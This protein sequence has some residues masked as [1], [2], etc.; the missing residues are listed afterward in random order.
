[1]TF[2]SK[3]YQSYYSTQVSRYAGSTDSQFVS[4]YEKDIIKFLPA[5]KNMRILE[6]GCGHGSLIK[7][8]EKKGYKN[9]L[10]IDYSKE[11]VKLAKQ[12]GINNVEEADCI[13][14]LSNKP[15]EFDIV[16]GVDVIEHFTK[17]ELLDL[18]DKVKSSLKTE[19]L[20][21]FRTPNCD[22]PFGTVYYFGDITHEIF[23]NAFSARQIMLA[24]GFSDVNVFSSA[25]IPSGWLKTIFQ[26]IIWFKSVFFFKL[27]LFATGRSTRD[28]F[29]T[30]NIIITAKK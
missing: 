13:Q 25:I 30:P 6:I 10:G 8:L 11:Q 27:I 12:N 22:A 29:F 14:Y 23:L 7:I 26:K 5:D 1:M 3:L 4:Q 24:S 28:V 2:R 21:I 9:I 18:L 20:V 17:N 16:I 19:G 15:E